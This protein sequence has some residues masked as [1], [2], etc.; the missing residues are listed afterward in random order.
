ML[1]YRA[2]RVHWSFVDF[3]RTLLAPLRTTPARLDLL[4]AL[5]DGDCPAYC[6]AIA[7][8]LGVARQTAHE[9]VVALERLGFVVRKPR[10]PGTRIVP[11]EVTPKARD[12]LDD[13]FAVFVRSGVA[14][15]SAA[16]TL[17]DAPRRAE[18]V[19]AFVAAARRIQSSLQTY[20]KHVPP[21]VSWEEADGGAPLEPRLRWVFE[22]A[23]R[24]CR[25]RFTW[26][27]Q[28]YSVEDIA[29]EAPGPVE[30]LAF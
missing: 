6:A 15:K 5:A 8:Y 28:D 23:L 16:R 20:G 10:E 2:K 4:Q 13:V 24:V 29:A 21:E 1:A 3:H 7:R 22:R 11:L 25:A 9:I 18:K 17:V 19:A 12:L 26:L 27:P 30:G 14:L